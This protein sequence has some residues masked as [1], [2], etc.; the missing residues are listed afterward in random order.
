MLSDSFKEVCFAGQ[1]NVGKSS[2][3][4]VIMGSADFH[5]GLAVVC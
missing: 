5:Q 1:S 3:V 4:N 2:L